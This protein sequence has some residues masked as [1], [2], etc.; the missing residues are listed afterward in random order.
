[1]PDVPH[2]YR[3]V[4]ILSTMNSPTT[5]RDASKEP[6]AFKTPETQIENPRLQLTTVARTA[7]MNSGDEQ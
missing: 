1:M 5:I 2:P 6:P 7:I 3:L 4:G